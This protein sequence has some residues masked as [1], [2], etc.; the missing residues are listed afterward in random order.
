MAEVETSRTVT[1]YANK[2]K[3]AEVT[4]VKETI[5]LVTK[6]ARTGQTL[7]VTEVGPNIVTNAGDLYYAQRGAAETPTYTFNLGEFVVARSFTRT[8]ATHGKT[9]TFGRFALTFGLY[10]GRKTFESGYPK[11][12]DSDT[13]NTGKGTDVVTYKVIYG[14]S[15]ANYTIRAI[16]V[17][18]RNATTNSNG[19]LLSYK[20]LTAAQQVQKTSSITL[21]A[22]LNHTFNGV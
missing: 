22:Y 9:C 3:P 18:R 17:C 12:N 16:G 8:V 10:T 11:T 1:P 15:E 19:Q 14:T 13:D 21:T 7:S 2:S 20:T 5:V 6:D 4:R